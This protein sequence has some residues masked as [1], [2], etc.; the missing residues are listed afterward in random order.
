[1]VD[2]P[3]ANIAALAITNPMQALVRIAIFLPRVPFVEAPLAP[4]MTR[5]CCNGNHDPSDG[6][7]DRSKATRP[8]PSAK[9]YRR[10]PLDLNRGLLRGLVNVGVV[11]SADDAIDGMAHPRLN[12]AG[13]VPTVCR[14]ALMNGPGDE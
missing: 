13:V 14:N 6:F 8:L 10:G 11:A 5:H 9:A 4:A 3:A 2:M 1:L 12:T 7:R